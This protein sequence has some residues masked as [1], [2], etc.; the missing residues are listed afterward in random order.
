MVFLDEYGYSRKERQFIVF[1]HFA[2]LVLS[3]SQ[4]PQ[5]ERRLPNA[6]TLSQ[7]YYKG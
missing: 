1:I 2:P 6:N 4:K 5:Q 3:L 7:E